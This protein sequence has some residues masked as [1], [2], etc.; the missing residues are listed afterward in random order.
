MPT[1][2]APRSSAQI[3]QTLTVHDHCANPE[4]PQLIEQLKLPARLDDQAGVEAPPLI[5]V[6]I[7]SPSEAEVHGLLKSVCYGGLQVLTPISVPLRCPVQVTI[8][9]CRTI[10][11]EVSYCVKRS[12]VYQAGI[13]LSCHHQP[14]IAIGGLAVINSLVEPFMVARGHILDIGSSSLWILCE[15]M[16]APGAWIRVKSNGWI[17]FGKMESILGIGMAAWCVGV[18]LEAAFRADSSAPLSVE[19]SQ[20]SCDCAEAQPVRRDNR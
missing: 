7:S 10:Q 20:R 15:A 6:Q 11:G 18:H 5:Q 14:D 9:G 17:L 4:R 1:T 12:S 13:V 3:V 16:L 2:E 8:A 19:R